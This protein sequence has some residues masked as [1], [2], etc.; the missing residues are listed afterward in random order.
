M[1]GNVLYHE[2]DQIRDEA[3]QEERKNNIRKMLEDG[4]TVQDI[5][6]FCKYPNEEV[7]AV[8]DAIATTQHND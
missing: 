4:R 3:I 8:A 5:V 2:A 7:Q 1:G 6:D